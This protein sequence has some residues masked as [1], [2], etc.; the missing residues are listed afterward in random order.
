MLIEQSVFKISILD[1]MCW[2]CTI[3]RFSSIYGQCSTILNRFLFLFS[4]KK[5]CLSGLEFIKC[6]SEY[7]TGKTLIRVV[8]EKQSDLG[9]PCLS[10]PFWQAASVQNFRTFTIH[11]YSNAHAFVTQHLIG[12]NRKQ[13]VT[14]S[15]DIQSEIV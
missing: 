14:I 10:R 6:L 11:Y 9:L 8:L 5:C 2:S 13:F 12:Y 15:C 3:V 4:N 7:Q 1:S